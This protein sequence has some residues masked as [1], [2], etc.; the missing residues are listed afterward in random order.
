[1]VKL[2][3]K[4]EEARCHWTWQG[5]DRLLWLV[6]YG[7]ESDLEGLVAD[8]KTFLEG[9]EK[10][11]LGVCDQTPSWVKLTSPLQLYHEAEF[12]RKRK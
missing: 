8:P 9:R 7:E 4:E 5:Y 1:M 6:A 3:P 10:T 11:V 12:T 2:S